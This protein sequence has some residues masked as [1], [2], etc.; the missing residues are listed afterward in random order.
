MDIGLEARRGSSIRHQQRELFVVNPRHRNNSNTGNGRIGT[1]D[2]VDEVDEL[3][4]L[5]E[6]KTL[7]RLYRAK[8]RPG[9][10]VLS[11]GP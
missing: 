7:S 6:P 11:A 3:M 2:D 1:P 5:R 9:G 10:Y 8:Q 4:K